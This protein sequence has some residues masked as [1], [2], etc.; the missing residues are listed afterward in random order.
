MEQ[1]AYFVS[2]DDRADKQLAPGVTIRVVSG[3]RLML[4]RVAIDPHSEVP[5]HSHPHEQYGLVLEGEAEFTIAGQVKL[6]KAGEYYA[7]PGDVP[8]GVITGSVPALCL[9]IFSP[10]REEYR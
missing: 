2:F 5:I 8:H 10:P 9:D 7:I 4:S 6:L 3:E 1:P